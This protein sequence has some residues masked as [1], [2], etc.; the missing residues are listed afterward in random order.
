MLL[1]TETFV[2]LQKSAIIIIDCKKYEFRMYKIVNASYFWI[3]IRPV[4]SYISRIIA[5]KLK[6]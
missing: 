3:L 6:K 2:G 4:L 1:N 5:A